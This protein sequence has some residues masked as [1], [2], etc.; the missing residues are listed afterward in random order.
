[1]TPLSV[2]I[3]ASLTTLN[4]TSVSLHDTDNIRMVL[5]YQLVLTAAEHDPQPNS[6]STSLSAKHEASVAAIE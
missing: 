3:L 2:E 5:G 6:F 4:D 1:M